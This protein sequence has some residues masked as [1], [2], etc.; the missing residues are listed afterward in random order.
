MGFSPDSYYA[1]V[2]LYTG[3]PNDP[4]CPT[5]TSSWIST[6]QSQGWSILPLYDGYAA[7]CQNNGSVDMSYNTTTARQQGASDATAAMQDATSEGQ[8]SAII[9]EDMEP[10][11]TGNSS[12]DAAVAAYVS[13][14]SQTLA[15]SS[16]NFVA[17]IY[18]GYQNMSDVNAASWKP[19]D[20]YISNGGCRASGQTNSCS[21]WNISGTSNS[22]WTGDQRIY[23]YANNF[24]DC[25]GSICQ[26]V[27][28]DAAS[29]T[30][31]GA[32][33]GDSDTSEGGSESTSSDP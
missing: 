8:A 4:G 18:I 22:T 29:G 12:C 9:Y 1:W 13:G 30:V 7:P 32:G 26:Q 28:A 16:G 5:P 10:F 33:G 27:D 19:S 11:P 14:W 23:Q 6:V 31:F 25:Y 20:V 21:A 17:G 15:Q 24:T 2:G 3:G